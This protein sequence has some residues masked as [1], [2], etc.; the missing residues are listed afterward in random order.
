MLG[1]MQSGLWDRLL[2]LPAAFFNRYSVAD[3]A[4]RL[5]G[6]ETIQDT[7]SAA[8]SRTLLAVV[9]L[10]FSMG[11]L[12]TY[13]AE[14]ALAV[15]GVTDGRPRSGHPHHRRPDAGDAGH[16]HRQ[17]PLLEHPAADRQG[18]RED[19]RRRRRGPSP[20]R[21]GR[22]ASPTR[23]GCCCARGSGPPPAPRSTPCS[24]PSSP[25]WSSA[26]CWATR[27]RSAPPRSCR[28]SPPWDRWPG[29]RRSS[30]SGWAACSPSRHVQGLGTHPG[31]AA[32]GGAAAADPGA[33][34]GRVA[35]SSV[36][37]RLPRHG[38]PDPPGRQ[39]H[40]RAG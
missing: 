23:R 26:S 2:A 17:G 33:L 28:S 29:L 12:F 21:V 8:A 14:L 9:T 20:G 30:T 36:E 6:V 37:L 13:S 31:G 22:R 39:P 16:V 3:L 40:G 32:G 5:N 38:P 10:V 19:P 4:Q 15:F 7:V 34:E 11:L 24:P 1:R 27:E 35:L 25:S 18:Q